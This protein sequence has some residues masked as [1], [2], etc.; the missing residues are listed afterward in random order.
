LSATLYRFY[1]EMRRGM[2]EFRRSYGLTG[3]NAGAGETERDAAPADENG[4]E[5][6]P[7]ASV[8]DIEA[9]IREIKIHHAALLEGYQQATHEGSKRILE[10]LDP[11][12]LR[13]E[14]EDA[15]IRV[16]PI[17]LRARWRPILV[18]AIWEEMLLRFQKYRSLEPSDFERFYR[19]GFRRGY[20]RF[21]AARL[22]QS[23]V[24][25]DATV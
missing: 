23:P 12:Q 7:P 16:G 19:D 6:I 18:Q 2:E 5:S 17:S 15:K 24:E 20:R 14:F 4:A 1:L 21:W 13:K 3:A 8:A 25:T 11:E 22:P 9:G 10:S